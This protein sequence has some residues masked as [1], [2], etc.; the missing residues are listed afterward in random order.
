[1]D[2]E[3]NHDVQDLP[4]VFHLNFRNRGGAW[5]AAKRLSDALVKVG[6]PSRALDIS[7]EAGNM[8]AGIYR[9]GSKIDYELNNRVLSASTTTQFS[10]FGV[11]RIL[12]KAI[13]QIPDKAIINMHWIPG[14]L[15]DEVLDIISTRSVVFTLH[16]MRHLTGYCHHADG[17]EGFQNICAACP[18]SPRFLQAMIERRFE[19]YVSQFKRLE[20]VAFVTPSDWLF[21]LTRHS[22]IAQLLPIYQ[23]YNPIPE[24]QY[25]LD[26][27]LK[28]AQDSGPIKICVHGEENPAKGGKIAMSVISKIKENSKIDLEI[29]VMGKIHRDYPNL[30]QTSIPE[31]TDE[32][33]FAE[34]LSEVDVLIHFSSVENSPNLIREA[35]SLGVY[36][37]TNDAGGSAELIFN[38]RTG[39]VTKPENFNE[40]L[41]FLL[42][43]AENNSKG[44]DIQNFDQP[45]KFSE[46]NLVAKYLDVYRSQI[47][48]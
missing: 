16:D 3:K 41:N 8:T 10:G 46:K 45:E 36:V 1:M 2:T 38:S 24:A 34:R 42:Y 33:K 37:I 47:K 19:M 43:L 13:M 5:K 22:Q 44:V 7:H 29:H 6:L 28:A 25:N 32:S 21:E 26:F 9:I 11:N 17:C 39:I 23:I 20:N 48:T 4:E 31:I 12:K 40:I 35:Q 27:K 15:N 14:N 18:Q 30:N